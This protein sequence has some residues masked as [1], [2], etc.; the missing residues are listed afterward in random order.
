MEL[1]KVLNTPFLIFGLKV[2][3]I[4]IIL[5]CLILLIFIIDSCVL[6]SRFSKLENVLKNSLDF[7]KSF[8]KVLSKTEFNEVN[9][10]FSNSKMLDQSWNEFSETILQSGDESDEI[11]NTE[12]IEKYLNEESIIN[13]NIDNN[14]YS[15]VPSVLTGIGLVGTFLSIL[16]GLSQVYVVKNG[17]VTGIEEL[18]NS[19]SGKF[20]SSIVGLTFSMW[21]TASFNRKIGLLKSRVLQLQHQFNK[22][23]SRTFSEKILLNIAKSIQGIG[24]N[25]SQARIGEDLNFLGALTEM[26]KQSNELKASNEEHNKKMLEVITTN[27]TTTNKNLNTAIDKLSKGAT[28]EI[29]K[30]LQGVIKDF[31]DKLT[32]QFGK[33][34]E[35]LN[36]AVFK[37][38]EWQENYKNT[39]AELD[40]GLK[41]SIEVINSVDKT[42]LS[43]SDRNAEVIKVY[44][45][46]KNTI[47]TYEQQIQNIQSRF[48]DFNELNQTAKDLLNELR[49][50]IN[51]TFSDLNKVSNKIQMSLTEQSQNL[52]E[53][54]KA[55]P[56][57]SEILNKR[58][59]TA[60]GQIESQLTESL[61]QMERVLVAITSKFGDTYKE[62]L[63]TNN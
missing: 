24:V 50:D 6:N 47:N 62:F 46:L 15:A 14:Y 18:I 31:N 58:L 40:K 20:I 55:L 13:A 21:F 45:D 30:A 26:I 17:S 33:N 43:I 56:E 7:L 63:K 12:Q 53:L 54:T 37:L 44:D 10:F 52:T 27:F 8:P 59:T 9:Q 34:F 51:S 32:E 1:F 61:S 3:L 25:F 49:T 28:E 39:I 38:V 23:F 4:T 60:S 36:E 57:H 5:S 41:A 22:L 35:E 29:I 16:I 2:P 42:L 19:L 11:Y 48:K